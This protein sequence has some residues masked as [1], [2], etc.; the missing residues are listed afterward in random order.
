MSWSTLSSVAP[1]AQAIVAH[2]LILFYAFVGDIDPAAFTTALGL[3]AAAHGLLSTPMAT[4][5]RPRPR[6]QLGLIGAPLLFAAIA[7]AFAQ[8]NLIMV[9]TLAAIVVTAMAS[10][11]VT[12]R[13]SPKFFR[14]VPWWGALG[15]SAA[16][17][18]G[19]LLTFGAWNLQ[20]L[21]DAGWTPADHDGGLGAWVIQAGAALDLSPMVALTLGMMLLFAF[22][23]IVYELYLL[24]GG[25]R[26]GDWFG[27]GTPEPA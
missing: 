6:K 17:V 26:F 12:A 11:C 19:L 14:S 9:L 7:A 8:W 15:R 22:H 24:A 10:L 5:K 3:Q 4:R 21:T 27:I 2:A 25:Q 16:T 20:K 1:L 23:E 18:L 13:R